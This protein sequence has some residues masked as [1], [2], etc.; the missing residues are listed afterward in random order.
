[1]ISKTHEEFW[2]CYNALPKA[3]QKLARDKFHLWQVDAFHS[4]LQFKELPKNVW[5]VRINQNYR[6]LGR[7]KDNLMV[8][9]WIG[10]HAEYDQLLKQ[11]S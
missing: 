10:T 8:W 1:M 7:R 9:F 3:A 5:S 11:L 4:S 6:A 2:N